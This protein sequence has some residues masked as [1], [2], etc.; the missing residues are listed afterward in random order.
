MIFGIDLGTCTS[1]VAYADDRGIADV[2]ALGDTANLTPSEVCL[3]ED[4]VAVV[5]AHARFAK[6]NEPS[7]DARALFR[8]FKREIGMSPP[9]RY[10]FRGVDWDPVGLSAMVLRKLRMDAD[11]AGRRLDRAV[12]THPQHFYVAQKNATVEAARIAGV[13]PVLTVSEPLAAAVAHGYGDNDV[14]G[15]VIL[16]DIGG[17]TLDVNVLEVGQNRLSV[18]ASDGDSHLGGLDFDRVM[19]SILDAPMR[20]AFGVGVAECSVAERLEWDRLCIRAKEELQRS[21]KFVANP[22]ADGRSMRVE[23]SDT[24]F[25]DRCAGLGARV[26]DAAS[27]ALEKSGVSWGELHE[28]ILVGG[29]A[30]LKLV[31]QWAERRAPGKWR[32]SRQPDLAVSRG[33]ALLGFKLSR[34]ERPDLDEGA[35][36]KTRVQ[37]RLSRHLGVMVEQANKRQPAVVLP[38]GSTI[39]TERTQTFRTATDGARRVDVDVVEFDDEGEPVPVG[40]LSVTAL[41]ADLP[42]GTPV[43]VTLSMGLGGGVAVRAA[44]HGSSANADLG[45]GESLVSFARE[46]AAVIPIVT[47]EG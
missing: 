35:A 20:S 16:V 8:L 39:P 12:I 22:V 27:R 31:Q 29:S 13:E 3:R 23:V 41:R 18:L 25:L 7:E 15:R 36:P 10:P 19:S 1:A 26:D 9:R 28:L 14:R 30:R 33:A 44:V 24:Y 46:R 11:A 37:N 4:G 32:M 34:G 42:R 40:R 21:K 47:E 45:E 43:E 6:A 38:A 5:G 2:P 17:G